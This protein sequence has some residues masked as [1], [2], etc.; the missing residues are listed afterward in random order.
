M[1]IAEVAFALPIFKTFHY[2]IP[3]RM[4]AVLQR[5]ARIR[6][7]FGSRQM[8]GV[9]VGIHAEHGSRVLKEIDSV[10]DPT[11]LLP[12]ELLDLAHWLSWRYFCPL[13]DAIQ[14]V[15]PS[16]ISSRPFEK[17]VRRPSSAAPAP[18]A[19][20]VKPFASPYVLTQDQLSAISRLGIKLREHKNHST[21][22]FGLPASGKTEVYLA[23]IHETLALGGQALWMLPEI[24]LTS[25]FMEQIKSR[26]PSEARV[27]HSHVPAKSRRQVWL[28]AASG[29]PMAVVGTRSACFL[30]FKNL[31]CVIVDEEQDESYRQEQAS[32]RY[33]AREVAAERAKAHEALLVLGSSTPSLETYFLATEKAHE[34]V[35]LTARVSPVKELPDVEI[36]NRRL[37]PGSLFCGRLLEKIEARIAKKEQVIL[38]VNRTGIGRCFYCGKCGW[39]ARCPSCGTALAHGIYSGQEQMRCRQCSETSPVPPACPGCRAE[40][41]ME[42]KGEGTLKVVSSLKREF[43]QSRILRLDRDT[44]RDTRGGGSILQDFTSQEADILVGTRLLAKGL[45]FSNVSLLGILDA[46]AW[47]YQS[48]FRASEKAF[49]FFFHALGRAGRGRSPGEVIIQTFHP[50]HPVF[51]AVHRKD[52]LRFAEE[53]LEFRRDLGYAPYVQIGHMEVSSVKKGLAEN[54]AHELAE[55]I[56]ALPAALRPAGMAELMEGQIAVLGPAAVH[57]RP[58]PAFSILLKSKRLDDLLDVFKLAQQ[59]PRPSAVKIKFSVE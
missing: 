49:H 30:P 40:G 20:A 46:D 44:V 17:L 14:T 43:P 10:V 4:S 37:E 39:L 13:G 47:L 28:E 6:A 34:I 1:A 5:G 42:H 56:L 26:L 52:Y 23:L 11:P 51:G 31:R 25:S 21:M 33:H 50:E 41:G 53:E 16:H 22:L 12:D 27:L 35:S 54:Y 36:V 24:S 15:F 32:P 48:D 3:A 45:H 8:S 19:P 29:E 9:V 38:L 7:P 55:K 2:A 59:S 57:G 58:S 18:G